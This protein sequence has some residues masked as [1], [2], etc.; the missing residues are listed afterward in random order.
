MFKMSEDTGG[1]RFYLEI[2][3]VVCASLLGLINLPL[4]CQVGHQ[5]SCSLINKM[6]FV[7]CCLALLHIPLVL[8]GFVIQMSC[9]FIT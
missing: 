8:H 9:T 1:E 5:F 6:I 2:V 4:L 7:D 3:A